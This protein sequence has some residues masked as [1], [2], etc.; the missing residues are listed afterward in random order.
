MARQLSPKGILRVSNLTPIALLIIVRR[1]F[2]DITTGGSFGKFH[3]GFSRR[4]GASSDSRL[5]HADQRVE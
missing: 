4:G 5:A 3:F 2:I 1:L